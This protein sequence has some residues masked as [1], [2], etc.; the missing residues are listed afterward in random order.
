MRRSRTK[1]DLREN[2]K[3]T[4]K[5]KQENLDKQE[6]QNTEKQEKEITDKREKETKEEN[7]SQPRASYK[8]LEWTQSRHASFDWDWTTNYGG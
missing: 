5:N 6:K 4:T 3:K 7:A 2:G 8:Q 1:T